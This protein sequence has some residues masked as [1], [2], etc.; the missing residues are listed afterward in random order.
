MRD[1]RE[2]E[3]VREREKERQRQTERVEM[4]RDNAQNNAHLHICVGS[5]KSIIQNMRQSLV[6]SYLQKKPPF[7][8]SHCYDLKD[9]I[10]SKF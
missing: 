4:K 9:C 2:R 6:R 5:Q 7:V 8:N 10:H 3:R 1:E